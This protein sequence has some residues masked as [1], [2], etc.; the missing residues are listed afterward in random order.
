MNIYEQRYNEAA[1]HFTRYSWHNCIY[2][3]AKDLEKLS[4][5][6]SDVS[7]PF[8]LRAEIHV[9]LNHDGDKGKRRIICITPMFNRQGDTSLLRLYYDTGDR[10]EKYAPNTL[11][12]FNGM[13]NISKP[14][15]DTIE[16]IYAA[17]QTY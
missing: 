14:L 15:P 12:D 16:E 4:G 9:Y 17:M 8:G 3:I 5:L 1:A 2:E 7:G 13:N 6:K 10:T 11:G